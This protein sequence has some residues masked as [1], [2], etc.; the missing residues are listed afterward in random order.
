MCQALYRPGDTARKQTP[1]AY[2]WEAPIVEETGDTVT[3][4]SILGGDN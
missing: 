2:T 3:R 4:Q 1:N